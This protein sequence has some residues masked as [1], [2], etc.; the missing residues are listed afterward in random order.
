VYDYDVRNKRGR[1][2]VFPFIAPKRRGDDFGD[3]IKPEDY[4]RAEEKDD[5]E[6]AD[7]KDDAAQDDTLGQKRKWGDAAPTSKGGRDSKPANKRA[8]AD[9]KH[10]PDDTAT[11]KVTTNRMKQVPKVHK[12]L[13]TAILHWSFTSR[14]PMS[15]S[16]GYS[17]NAIYRC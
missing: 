11:K 5:M 10:E 13:C 8:K 15:T 1:E 12:R 17:R 7:T 4:L 6:G 3:I 9:K 2:K 16:P 14:S